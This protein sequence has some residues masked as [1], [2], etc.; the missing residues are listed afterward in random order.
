MEKALAMVLEQGGAKKGKHLTFGRC[1]LL[2]QEHYSEPI[3][4][5]S[6][7]RL[8]IARNK[9]H[10][11]SSWYLGLASV[12]S[13]TASKGFTVKFNPD[14]HWSAAF[15]RGLDA[16]QYVC[17]RY[18][19]VINRDD[20]AGFRLGRAATLQGHC[21]IINGCHITGGSLPG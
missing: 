12:V 8:C 4:L 5:G 9:R 10:R 19:T 13:R 14:K 15:Y 6:V 18:I 11:T 3:S 16:L 20:Q 21:H 1:Q 17:G 7:K 2:L